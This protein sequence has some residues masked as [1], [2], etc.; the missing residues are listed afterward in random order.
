M[1]NNIR[2]TINI[3]GS[4][5]EMLSYTGFNTNNKSEAINKFIT[6]MNTNESKT[7]I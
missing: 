6:Y 3:Y 1:T 7:W 2:L 5:N 4:H